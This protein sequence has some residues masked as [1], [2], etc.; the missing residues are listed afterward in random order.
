MRMASFL[1][2]CLLA[3]PVIAAAQ[4]H[5]T[6]AGDEGIKLVLGLSDGSQII[7]TPDIKDF[8]LTTD[9]ATMDIPLT[10]L[11]TVELSGS[12]A[13]KA[14]L[15]N[16][17]SL[18]GHLAAT[19]IAVETLFGHAV[20]PISCVRDIQVTGG[21][22]G[23]E[24][25][26]DGLVLHYTFDA[27]QGDRVTDASGN[28]NDGKVH[29]ATYT[30]D[31]K[32]GGAMSFNGEYEAVTAGNPAGLKLQNFSIMAWIKRGS[33][34][35]A[36]G[37][38]EDAVIFGYG[39]GGYILGIHPDGQLFLSKIDFDNVPADCGI[40]DEDYH[41][42]AVT[43]QGSKIVF[44]LDGTAY[45]ASDYDPGFAF[46]T[47]AAVGARADGLDCS[48]IGVIDEVMVFNRALSSDEVKGI[49]DA[50]K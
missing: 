16:G 26:P 7:G 50:Q 3:G 13:I 41:H 25:F 18:S 31:G 47:D 34:N 8:K 19:E 27:D 15:K 43:K 28:G 14:G 5:A 32:M 33:V 38:S 29:G 42:V 40:Q 2:G 21:P 1:L 23:A 44:Y 36:S 20:I 37:T 45:P 48:F 24:S 17:D 6:P 4:N 35:K 49:Y 39:H 30:N 46:V 10:L 22:R 11:S 12:G 9:Y